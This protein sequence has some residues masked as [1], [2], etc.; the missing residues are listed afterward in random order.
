MNN[1][2]DDYVRE[3]CEWCPYRRKCARGDVDPADCPSDVMLLNEIDK[4][5]G[6]INEKKDGQKSGFWNTWNI[7]TQCQTFQKM[8]T[9][10]LVFSYMVVGKNVR[11]YGKD[12]KKEGV[13]NETERTDRRI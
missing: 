12:V 5:Q 4:W 11:S 9:Q 2:E 10:S 1:Y 8:W 6:R 3:D 7:Q 13:D